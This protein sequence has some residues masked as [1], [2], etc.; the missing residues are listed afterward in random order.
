MKGFYDW[1]DFA[2]KGLNWPSF[3]MYSETELQVCTQLFQ[4][5]RE[6]YSWTESDSEEWEI[7]E[8]YSLLV[9]PK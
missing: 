2:I 3:W 5:K 8:C 7:L 9:N 4:W 1:A 6:A